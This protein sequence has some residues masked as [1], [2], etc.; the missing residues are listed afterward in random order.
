MLD[1]ILNEVHTVLLCAMATIVVLAGVIA[2]D[3]RGHFSVK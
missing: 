1:A 3:L 2:W